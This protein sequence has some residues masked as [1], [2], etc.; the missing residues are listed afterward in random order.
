MMLTTTT[1]KA[2]PSIR[3]FFK[4]LII[5]VY[6]KY[7][8]VFPLRDKKGITITNVF[9]KILDVSKSEGPKPNKK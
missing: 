4:L 9:Q 2:S 8:W 6:G 3:S 7:E 1:Y 5:D